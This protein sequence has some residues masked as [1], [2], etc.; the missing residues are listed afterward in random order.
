VRVLGC[1]DVTRLYLNA[2]TL[3]DRSFERSRYPIWYLP[4]HRAP[5]VLT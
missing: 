3:V 5:V 2:R 4:A 1:S